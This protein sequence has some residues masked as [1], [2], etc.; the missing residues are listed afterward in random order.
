MGGDFAP[1]DRRRGNDCYTAM[2]YP[3]NARELDAV[4]QGGTH[5]MYRDRIASF[6]R[7]L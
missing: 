5:E 4:K 2:R 1:E 6:L 3:F 7:G